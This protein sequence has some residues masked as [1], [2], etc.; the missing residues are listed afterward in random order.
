[1]SEQ[2]AVPSPAEKPPIQGGRLGQL[3]VIILGFIVLADWLF[4]DRPRGWTV[5]AYGLLLLAIVF[6]WE[7]A[8]P[9]RRGALLVTLAAAMLCLQ[10]VEQP[11]YLTI[12]C[13]AAGVASLAIGLREGWSRSALIWLQR[14]GLLAAM[15]WRCAI[16]D[17]I[18]WNR[19][20]RRF[21]GSYRSGARLA[22]NWSVPIILGAVFVALFTV[23]NPVMSNWLSTAWRSIRDLVERLAEGFPSAWRMLLWV[24]VG[25][26]VWA[27]LRFRSGR[28]DVVRKE[29]A[30]LAATRAEFPTPALIV[31]CLVVFNGLFAVQTVLDVFYLWCGAQLP[32]GLTYAEYA[33]RGAYPL[34]AAAILAALFVLVALRGD[35]QDRT[36]RWARRLTYAWLAQNLLLV[37]SA[38]WRLRLY[39]EVY[40]LTRWRV[41]AAIWMLLVF[42]G[43][44]WIL[45]RIVAR[46]SNL[47]LVNV[48]TVTTV[49]VLFACC[50]ADFDARI[51]RFNVSHCRETLGAGPP[52]DLAYL[53]HLG[54]AALPALL[55]LVAALEDTP[56]EEEVLARIRRLRGELRDQ[57]AFWHGWT[58]RRHRLSQLGFPEEGRASVRSR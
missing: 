41:G 51:A 14:L 22:R 9:R 36:L 43:L 34:V 33:H 31:R 56:A 55:T 32:D 7:R 24:L 52:I 42:C 1:M 16:D 8:I 5:G 38:A 12:A 45:L 11:D 18:G 40:T 58:W 3:L 53:E 28:A 20:R 21:D 49:V 48:N 25:M 37:A 4:W 39:I 13:G 27:L 6:F 54:P 57:L 2:P 26:S 15:G 10:C 44:T 46:R 23:A 30:T 50:F 17:V 47:W 35:P 19:H 29:H